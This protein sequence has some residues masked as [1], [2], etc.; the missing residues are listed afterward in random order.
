[1][2]ISKKKFLA[3]SAVATGF[4]VAGLAVAADWVPP[5]NWGPFK[6][7]KCKVAPY[8]P[9]TSTLAFLK[10]FKLTMSLKGERLFTNDTVTVCAGSFCTTY[11]LT[12]SGDFLGGGAKD[13]TPPGGGGTGDGGNSG[14]GHGGGGGT[15]LGG[16]GGCVGNCTGVVTVKPP[17]QENPV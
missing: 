6:C 16:S 3:L 9:D 7:D 4:V 8:M 11:T 10:D 14:G 17:F 2:K 12:D 13:N 5:R 15:N 1:M